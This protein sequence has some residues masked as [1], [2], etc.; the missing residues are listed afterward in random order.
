MD[1]FKRRARKR[2]LLEGSE[3]VEERIRRRL[4]ELQAK[5]E[6][7]E[8]AL[9]ER[10]AKLQAQAEKQNL[11]SAELAEQTERQNERAAQLEAKSDKLEEKR[12]NL[13][14][15]IEKAEAKIEK[16]EAKIEK[17]EEKLAKADEALA[18]A[19]AKA[20]QRRRE[21]TATLETKRDNLDEKIATAEDKLRKI[22]ERE[23]EANIAI[24]AK[25][26]ELEEKRAELLRL[27]DDIRLHKQTGEVPDITIPAI[28]P[29]GGGFSEQDFAAG[30]ASRIDAGEPND[31]LDYLVANLPQISRSNMNRM[32]KLNHLLYSSLQLQHAN[33]AKHGWEKLVRKKDQAKRA[34]EEFDVDRNSTFLDF[35][36]GAHDPIALAGNFYMNGFSRAIAC[37][38]LEPRNP[39]YSALSMYQILAHAKLFPQL[40]QLPQTDPTTFEERFTQF[41]SEA[42]ADG[43]WNEAVGKLD[44]KVEHHVS[45]V[46]ELPVDDGEVGFVV[47]FAVLEHLTDLHGVMQWL[48]RKSKRGAVQFHFID[49]ADH[50]S[51]GGDSDFDA[52]SF[53]TEDNPPDWMNRLRKSQ[54]IAAIEEAGFEIVSLRDTQEDIPSETRKAFLEPWASMSEEDLKTTKMTVI[55]R[56]N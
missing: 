45:D 46:V 6:E 54:H 15:K 13:E 28:G 16:A 21:L 30:F 20:E 32:E 18:K 23:G 8:T 31:A 49:I 22:R 52:W 24:D 55:F 10:T 41:D 48:Y 14:A 44:G 50:R 33:I 27:Y 53:L 7:R 29:L 40:F 4:E 12:Q 37:D 51:Y 43:R 3:V 38:I 42:F 2:Y 9:D 56:K 17:A 26:A 19:E 11:R 36:C 5:L 39:T 34:F 25:A 47:S 1:F 35:G